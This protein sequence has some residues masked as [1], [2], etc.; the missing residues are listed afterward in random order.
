MI[1]LQIFIGLCAFAALVLFV[2]ITGGAG[3]ILIWYAIVLAAIIVPAIWALGK[4]IEAVKRG[5][6]DG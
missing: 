1:A 5:Y 2:L 3:L 4:F 6:R